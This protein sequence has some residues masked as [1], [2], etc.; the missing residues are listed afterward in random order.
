[1]IPGPSGRTRTLKP[2]EFNHR[3]SPIKNSHRSRG[4]LAV[5]FDVNDVIVPAREDSI[6]GGIHEKTALLIVVSIDQSPVVGVGAALAIA[7]PVPPG[8]D[9]A[10]KDPQNSSR[11]ARRPDTSAL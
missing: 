6:S 10:T 3:E 11:Q 4:R 9:S 5:P 2:V 1:L 8:H 7:G